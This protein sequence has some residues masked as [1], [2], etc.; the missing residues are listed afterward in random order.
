MVT[1]KFAFVVPKAEG[2]N[3]LIAGYRSELILL[4]MIAVGFQHAW[5]FPWR[6]AAIRDVGR[7][8]EEVCQQQLVLCLHIDKCAD[9]ASRKRRYVETPHTES[10]VNVVARRR[11]SDL[12]CGFTW[13]CVLCRCIILRVSVTVV[14]CQYWSKHYLIQDNNVTVYCMQTC[15]LT[16]E[17][18]AHVDNSPYRI[19]FA[20]SS[21]RDELP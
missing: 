11:I 3:V 14:R 13:I 9:S 18:H 8:F 7:W 20:S 21:Q 17:Q 16:V 4:Q 12:Y 10:G 5:S 15:S 1:G 2:S 19:Y 6:S